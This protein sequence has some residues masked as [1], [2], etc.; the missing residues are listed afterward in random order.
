MMANPAAR[1]AVGEP[2]EVKIERGKIREFAAA[3]HSANP[4]YWDDENPLVPP[5]FLTTQM[6]WESWAGQ[7][8]SPWH[9]VDLDQQRG[10]HA[11]QEYIFHGPPP[12]AGTRLT[13]QSRIGDIYT[14]QGSSGPLTFAVMITEFRDESGRLVA[15]AKLTGVEA[16]PPADRS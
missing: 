6:F 8:S 2:F 13:A 10:V 9:L 1:G 15:E 3:T 4:A 12:R 7:A 5:T 11:E 16:A 14:K